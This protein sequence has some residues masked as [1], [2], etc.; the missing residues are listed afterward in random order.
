MYVLIFFDFFVYLFLQFSFV[1]FFFLCFLY[2]YRGGEDIDLVT[3]YLRNDYSIIRPP[4]FHLVHRYHP[5]LEWRSK[6][7]EV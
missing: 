6:S 3:K 2:C 4:E 7:G 1:I 5:T